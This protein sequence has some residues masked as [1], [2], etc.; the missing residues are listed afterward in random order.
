[1]ENDGKIIINR[2]FCFS[3]GDILTTK[4]SAAALKKYAEGIE[5]AMKLEGALPIILDTNILL[6]YYGMSQQEKD[7]LRKFIQSYSPRIY[8]T[9]QIEKEYLRNRVSVIRK[10]FFKPLTDIKTDFV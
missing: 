3:P 1:M 4:I 8:I 5:A 2:D 10:D 9:T 6:G 7:K